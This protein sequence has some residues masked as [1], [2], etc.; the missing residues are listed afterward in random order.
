MNP[1]I[2]EKY[3]KNYEIKISK[4]FGEKK[5]R[6]PIHLYDGNEKHIIKIFKKIKKMTGFFV[7]GEVIT[8]VCLKVF[9]KTK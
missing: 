9:Q 4:L 3:L 8:N 1:K 5:I 2:D 6:G 7:H